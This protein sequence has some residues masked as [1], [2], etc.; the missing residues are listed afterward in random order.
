MSRASRRPWSAD[1]SR[2]HEPEPSERSGK[3]NAA[4]GHDELDEVAALDREAKA[5]L[6]GEIEHD[7]LTG[8]GYH[9]VRRVARTIA[10]LAARDDD[11]VM[12]AD[13]TLAL[14][15]RAGLSPRRVETVAERWTA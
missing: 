15:L 5:L 9:R 11:R 7:R 6:R 4:L 8:R 2:W 1:G 12:L 14:S 3:L 13:V 10:D